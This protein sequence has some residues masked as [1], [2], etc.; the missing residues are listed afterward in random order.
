[1]LGCFVYHGNGKYINMRRK[2][3]VG[4][5]DLFIKVIKKAEVRSS[6]YIILYNRLYNIPKT[7]ITEED[8]KARMGHGLDIKFGGSTPYMY[9]FH[10]TPKTIFKTVLK[11]NELL[12]FENYK[13]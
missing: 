2:I 13:E 4:V 10:K 6:D 11:N 7:I 9:P 3:Y 8:L 5:S 12:N 1:M